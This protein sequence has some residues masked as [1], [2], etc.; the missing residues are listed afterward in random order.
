MFNTIRSLTRTAAFA[1]GFAALTVAPQLTAGEADK[2]VMMSFSAPVEIPGKV[3][4]AGNYIFRALSN[5]PNVILVSNADDSRHV[6][7][8]M[9]LPTYNATT[10]EKVHVDFA[11]RRSDKPPAMK[12]WTYPGSPTGFEL[13]YPDGAGAIR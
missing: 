6:G 2:A 13:V 11:E 4:P 9:T 7:V 8:T 1:L 5:S 12:S 10:P 3:L